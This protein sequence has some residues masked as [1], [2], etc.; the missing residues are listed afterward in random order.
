M[1]RN[2]SSCCVDLTDPYFPVL[3]MTFD[4]TMDETD[5]P[6]LLDFEGTD[7]VGNPV[8]VQVIAW[9][10]STT[11]RTHLAIT[12]G[13]TLSVFRFLGP[14]PSLK[15]LSGIVQDKFTISNFPACPW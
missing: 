4:Q 7:S 12:N 11:L 5:K 14:L 2:Y 10:S 1:H 3:L 15:T 6:G 13:S 9:D 8:D